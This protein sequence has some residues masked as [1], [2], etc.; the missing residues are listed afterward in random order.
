MTWMNKWAGGFPLYLEKAHGNK[1]PRNQQ[2]NPS[3]RESIKKVAWQQ[4]CQQL[5]PNLSEPNSKKDLDFL[6][7]HLLSAQPMPTDGLLELQDLL[8]KNLKFW[9]FHTVITAVSM[10]HS[11]LLGKTESQL[12]GLGSLLLQ[13][14]RQWQLGYASSMTLKD[15]K[16]N[17]PMEMWQ[18]FW[19]SQQ[20]LTLELCYRKKGF[21]NS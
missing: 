18:Q 5:M 19:W 8:R 20:W 6:C 7:G 17:W 14:V 3:S 21:C 9:S 16:I 2:S 10:R 1:L 11:W 4:W 12:T 13:S 15:L